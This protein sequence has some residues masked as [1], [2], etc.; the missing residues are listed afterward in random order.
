METAQTTTAVS[1]TS[2]GPFLNSKKGDDDSTAGEAPLIR[3]RLEVLA[4]QLFYLD[5]LMQSLKL[6][7]KK[8]LDSHPA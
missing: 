3:E 6:Q 8:F 1:Y 2:L 4:G 7:Y 5:S